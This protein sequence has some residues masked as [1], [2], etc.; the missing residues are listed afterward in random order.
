MAGRLRMLN[1]VVTGLY[2][3][4]LRPFNLRLTQMSILVAIAVRGPVLA[5]D[6]SRGMCI[7][8]STLSRDLERLLERD[9]VR[10][11]RQDGRS[12]L[13][14]ITD[15][16]RNL[17]RSAEAAWEEVQKQTREVLGTSLTKEL[18]KAGH[19]LQDRQ[20]EEI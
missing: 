17:I 8:K 4:A 18:I 9:L 14:E 15:K 20:S 11:R 19:R 5:V 16:G 6:L 7:E 13:L 10:E 1:R 3:D 12:K 2:D